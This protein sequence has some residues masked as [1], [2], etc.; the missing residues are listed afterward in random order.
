MLER[1]L[2]HS[3]ITELIGAGGMGVVYHA[4]DRICMGLAGDVSGCEF[5][6]GAPAVSFH[7]TP[8]KPV[9]ATISLNQMEGAR[10]GRDGICT[11]QPY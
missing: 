10:T 4:R 6:V 7:I 5:L 11:P 1:T 9:P 3:R 2:G 8:T